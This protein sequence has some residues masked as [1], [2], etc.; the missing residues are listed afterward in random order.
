MGL[1]RAPMTGGSWPYVPAQCPRCRYIHELAPPFVDDSGYEILG[2]CLHPRIG[3][4]LFR[5][6]ERTAGES[7][8]CPCFVAAPSRPADETAG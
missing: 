6:K 5:A 7:G 1:R 3:M 2:F 8:G 4:E